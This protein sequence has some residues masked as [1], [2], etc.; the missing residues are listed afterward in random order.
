MKK[1][2]LSVKDQEV[3]NIIMLKIV[4]V[5]LDAQLKYIKLNCLKPRISK[6]PYVVGKIRNSILLLLMKKRVVTQGGGNNLFKI[7]GTDKL[8]IY[9]VYVG[10]V[11]DR[12]KKIGAAINLEDALS[13]IKSYSGNQIKDIA[14]W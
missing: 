4:E 14:E 9:I 13:I 11:F 12:T 8:E 6:E 2:F 1:M 3:K 10:Y 5:F 7:T